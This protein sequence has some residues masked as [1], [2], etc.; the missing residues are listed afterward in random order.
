MSWLA[1]TWTQ[2]D[3]LATYP[4]AVLAV[5]FDEFLGD[6]ERSVAHICRHLRLEA[7][8]RYLSSVAGSPTLARYSKATEF[9]YSPQVRAQLLA[10]SRLRHGHEIRRGLQWLEDLALREPRVGTVLAGR[11]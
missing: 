1:E 5:D 6:V 8:E 4:G 3:L 11:L 7:D 9:E 2:V 10:D